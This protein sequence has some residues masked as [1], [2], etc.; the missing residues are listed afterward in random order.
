MCGVNRGSSPD[1]AVRCGSNIYWRIVSYCRNGLRVIS[2]EIC[3]DWTCF[4][5]V[6]ARSY[7]GILGLRNHSVWLIDRGCGLVRGAVDCR[8]SYRRRNKSTHCNILACPSRPKSI[9]SGSCNLVGTN[10]DLLIRAGFCQIRS[11]RVGLL[12]VIKV[13]RWSLDLRSDRS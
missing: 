9:C 2:N 10:L 12:R 8:C 7:V 4:Y 3:S 1:W 6:R 13:K 11:L 5:S